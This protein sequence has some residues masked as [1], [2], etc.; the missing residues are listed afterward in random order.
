MSFCLP[1]LSNLQ[2]SLAL[3]VLVVERAVGHDIGDGHVPKF[4]PLRF[5]RVPICPSGVRHN[6]EQTQEKQHGQPL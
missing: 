5:L 1:V 3:A 4:L 6:R 2:P